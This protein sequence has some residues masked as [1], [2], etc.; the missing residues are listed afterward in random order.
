MGIVFARPAVAVVGVPVD[1]PPAGGARGVGSAQLA[2]S[3]AHFARRDVGAAQHSVLAVGGADEG[4]V[5][6]LFGSVVRA[7][8]RGQVVRPGRAEDEKDR[9]QFTPSDQSEASTREPRT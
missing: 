5:V 3:P 6:G 4:D 9:L 2:V 8:G 1:T 7:E